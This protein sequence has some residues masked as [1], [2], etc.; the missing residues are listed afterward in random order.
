MDINLAVISCT[1]LKREEA[2]QSPLIRSA[3]DFRYRND[4]IFDIVYENTKGLPQ[5]YNEK[6]EQ[7][8]NSDINYLLFVHDDVYIDDLKLYEKIK[9]AKKDCGYDIVGLAGCLNPRLT[10][11]ALWHLMS[12]IKDLRGQVAHPIAKGKSQTHMSAFGMTPSRVAIIDGLFIGV[13][14][15]SILDKGW[16]FNENYTFHHYDMASCIDANRKGLKIG[17]YP[18]HVIH[19]S[20]GLLSV[21]DKLWK[22][23]N[24]KF[25]QEYA[26]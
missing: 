4:I 8:K 25:L 1:R 13:H 9:S 2:M 20:P 17:V 15:P 22:T 26:S 24:E 14:L 23:S 16:R 12:D 3:E 7:Y 21:E 5:V 10:N 11:P 18:I 19:Q 6:I